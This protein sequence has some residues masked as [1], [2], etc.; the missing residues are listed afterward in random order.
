MNTI[1]FIKVPAGYWFDLTF[2]QQSSKN[3]RISGC[4]YAPRHDRKDWRICFASCSGLFANF[5]GK[6]QDFPILRDC[7]S[8]VQQLIGVASAKG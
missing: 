4:V 8:H 5:Q 1:V 3:N 2:D 7:K 6:V